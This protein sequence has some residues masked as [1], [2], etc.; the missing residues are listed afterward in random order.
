MAASRQ[1]PAGRDHH[2]QSGSK[3]G[4][5]LFG[6]RSWRYFSS[7]CCFILSASCRCRPFASCSPSFFLMV[8]GMLFA[9]RREVRAFLPASLL[10]PVATAAGSIGGLYTYDV[11][12]I[13]PQFYSNARVYADVI[14]SQPSAAVA[15][16]GKLVFAPSTFVDT[17][18][19]VAYITE[20]GSVFCVA[21]VRDA[22]QETQI[23][24][25]AVG[26][27]CCS[28]G[29]GDFWCDESQ[30]KQATGGVV[31]F[32]NEGIFSSSSYDE[33]RKASRK[34][35]ATY[36]LVSVATPVYVRW[37]DDN[38]LDAVANEFNLK[39]A[40]TLCGWTAAY[41][42]ISYGLVFLT[43]KLPG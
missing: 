2:F 31:I 34:A 40:L 38:R 3:Q 12:A 33:Y 36:H 32:D 4:S 29:G 20:R 18:H 11:Y 15:D 25:W 24:Y 1:N 37:F 27:S 39:T 41:A 28:I 16:A 30:N 19:S 8:A 42:F 9:F 10:L 43:G 21:P 5:G 22:N 14:P 23:E 17:A 26:T 35:E 7:C 13:Y 6:A